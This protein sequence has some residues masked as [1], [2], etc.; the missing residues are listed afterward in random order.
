[1]AQFQQAEETHYLYLSDIVGCCHL[2]MQKLC[3]LDEL[4]KKTI[5]K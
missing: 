5:E 3:F 4:P 1:M 2:S